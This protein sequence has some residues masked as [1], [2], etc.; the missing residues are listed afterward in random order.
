M[1]LSMTCAG[2]GSWISV[3]H[4]SQAHFPTDVA[5]DSED[6]RR[7]VEFFAGIFADTLERA[8][9]LAVAVFRFVMDQRAR[10]MRWQCCALGLLANFAFNR[11]RLQRFKLSFDGS[12]I[13]VRM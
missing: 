5:L 9:A 1:P 11:R 8:A 10:E 6:A 3:S 13:G 4:C 7:V 2:T 12:D